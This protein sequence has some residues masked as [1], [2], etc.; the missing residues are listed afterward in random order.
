MES[1]KDV[2]T[3]KCENFESQLHQSSKLQVWGFG[4]SVRGK[5]KDFWSHRVVSESWWFSWKQEMDCFCCNRLIFR[6]PRF[7]QCKY[8]PF[9]H[10]KSI[11]LWLKYWYFRQSDRYWMK[12]SWLSFPPKLRILILGE[13]RGVEGEIP[14]LKQSGRTSKWSEWPCL[15][16]KTI[17]RPEIAFRER[18]SKKSR[19]WCFITF[20]K[21]PF[22]MR[23]TKPSKIILEKIPSLKQSGM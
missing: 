9:Q 18:Y 3:E 4:R 7:R 19:I 5:E 1:R 11:G 22:A 10:K 13:R 14:S 17:H 23:L 8:K 20:G 21:F 12:S 2:N 6:P 16:S 15:Q